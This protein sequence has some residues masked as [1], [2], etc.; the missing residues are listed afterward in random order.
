MRT[1]QINILLVQ[2]E[3]P[4]AKRIILIPREDEKAFFII[5]KATFN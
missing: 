4:L 5:I 1:K 2:L 3:F